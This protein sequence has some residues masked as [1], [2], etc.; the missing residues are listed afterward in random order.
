MS[1]FAFIIRPGCLWTA[2]NGQ[3]PICATYVE[4]QISERLS[5]LA[6]DIKNDEACA[7][8]RISV[9]LTEKRLND[10][11]NGAGFTASRIPEDGS[12]APEEF[13][14][15]YLDCVITEDYRFANAYRL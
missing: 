4:T 7:M 11:C 1:S 13:V 14:D 3:T 2:W 5:I 15:P 12:M 9:R 6:I 8:G 10:R